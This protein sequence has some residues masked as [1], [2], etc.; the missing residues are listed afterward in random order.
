MERSLK[1]QQGTVSTMTE[2]RSVIIDYA[3]IVDDMIDNIPA[4]NTDGTQSAIRIML[5]VV[6]DGDENNNSFFYDYDDDWIHV[7]RNRND[8]VLVIR[9]NYGVDERV[10]YITFS[11]NVDEDETVTIKLIQLASEYTIRFGEEGSE[12]NQ[13]QLISIVTN[14]PQ[15]ITV[16]VSCTGGKSDFTV[17]RPKKY[18]RVPDE[19]L[20]LTDTDL[21]PPIYKQVAFDNAF[22][23]IKEGSN[24]R[25]ENYGNVNCNYI[26]DDLIVN[27]YYYLVTVNHKNSFD[28][29]A[30]IK[31]IYDDVNTDLPNIAE[32]TPTIN[33]PHPPTETW[34]TV[35]E[36]DGDGEYE[37]YEI[38]CD[39]EEITFSALQETKVIHVETT[40]RDSSITFSYTG[41]F[42]K[43][44]KIVD[45]DVHVTV[46]ENIFYT[47]RSCMCYLSN[48]EEPEATVTLVITQAARERR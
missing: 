32:A 35:P 20:D 42:I 44:Y 1:I 28:E 27:D 34:P 10:G 19:L 11:H 17:H 43:K 13:V 4:I 31:V 2:D 33:A 48:A 21:V 12:T 6:V 45:H 3:D 26:E 41:S 18:V 39:E 46:K 38:T 16:P 8:L 14:S 15:E 29:V 36:D 5:R 9:E 47:E 23:V 22:N 7:I 40:P 25:I 24:I 30:T 37:T